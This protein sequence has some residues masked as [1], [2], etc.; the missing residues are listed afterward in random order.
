[1]SLMSPPESVQFTQ[2]VLFE[3]HSDS[4][5][6]VVDQSMPIFLEQCVD[7]WNTSIPT[8]FE[9]FEGDSSVLYLC[10]LSFQ[11]V[12]S[13]NSVGVDELGLPRHDVSVEIGDELIFF[14]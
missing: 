14:M 12:F 4:P 8:V 6:F 1:M 5:T 9:I 10:F 13:P 2:L 7:S 3:V 11:T